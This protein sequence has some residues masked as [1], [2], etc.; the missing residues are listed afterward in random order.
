MVPASRDETL[1]FL[2][3]LWFRWGETVLRQIGAHYN[4]NIE[5]RDA[6]LQILSRPNDWVVAVEPPLAAAHVDSNAL[7]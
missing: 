4:L 3:A 1:R 5:Q 7:P 2:G 6:L